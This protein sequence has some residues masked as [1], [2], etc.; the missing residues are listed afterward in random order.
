MNTNANQYKRSGSTVR[1]A[2]ARLEQHLRLQRQLLWHPRL[3]LVRARQP[4]PIRS[5]QGYGRRTAR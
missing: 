5:S 2:L 4:V 1:R 3:G